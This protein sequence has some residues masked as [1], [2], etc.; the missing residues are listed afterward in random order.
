MGARHS[1]SFC[2]TR[3]RNAPRACFVLRLLE[4]WFS[5]LS[6]SWSWPSCQ[7][8]CLPDPDAPWCCNIYLHDCVIIGVNVGKYSIHGASG[9]AIKRLYQQWQ[10]KGSNH[11]SGKMS[12]KICFSQNRNWWSSM[13]TSASEVVVVHPV[14]T[15]F[16]FQIGNNGTWLRSPRIAFYVQRSMT[17]K[18]RVT[19][20]GVA[21]LE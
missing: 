17:E 13:V 2:H 9:R 3:L 19:T 7:L 14:E 11:S 8:L 18:G 6:S 21:Y 16:L 5:S 4:T 1:Q 20:V 10:E 12:G 15:M